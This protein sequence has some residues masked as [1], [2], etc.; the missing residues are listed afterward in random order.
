MSNSSHVSQMSPSSIA[1][2]TCCWVTDASSITKRHMNLAIKPN[3]RT[4]NTSGC[5][6]L[7]PAQAFPYRTVQFTHWVT[8]QHDYI[9]ERT[10]LHTSET[11]RKTS[12]KRPGGNKFQTCLRPACYWRQALIRGIFSNS[13]SPYTRLLLEVGLYL[14]ARRLLEVLRYV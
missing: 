7:Q 2:I 6:E 10:C 12:N 9:P 4:W 1:S 14:E 8:L 5:P 3:T 13:V 11:Y